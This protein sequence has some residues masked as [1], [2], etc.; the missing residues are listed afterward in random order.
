MSN[1]CSASSSRARSLKRQLSVTRPMLPLA[2]KAKPVPRRI[3]WP[4]VVRS[5]PYLLVM[6]HT[7]WPIRRIAS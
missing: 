3:T 2:G 6:I 1:R 7:S 5:L 4:S